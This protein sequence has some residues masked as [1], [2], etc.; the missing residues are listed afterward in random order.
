L[1]QG[2]LDPRKWYKKLNKERSQEEG[3]LTCIGIA[4][5]R[6]LVT[7]AGNAP[8]VRSPMWGIM[9]VPRCAR[10][11]EL[12]DVA[13]GAVAHLDPVGRGPRGVPL[14]RLQAHVVEE[15]DAQ[16]RERAPDAHLRYVRQEGHEVAGVQPRL[17]QVLGVLVELKRV[18]LLGRGRHRVPLSEDGLLD[19]AVGADD[20]D[21]A[22]VRVGG[23]FADPEFEHEVLVV[24][25]A[26]VTAELL[27]KGQRNQIN[28]GNVARCESG[29]FFL[30]SS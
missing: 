8:R 9:S 1:V 29:H 18:H 27:C 25:G 2:D 13:H 26:T 3:E 5:I 20:L 17:P 11:A 15:A 19:R 10:L 22:Q 14:G 6:M 28:E 23:V 24:T 4:I 21:V 7:V 16:G 12:S 30:E